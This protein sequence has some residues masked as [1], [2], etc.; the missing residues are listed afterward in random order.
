M[1][2]TA[3]WVA[4]ALAAAPVRA[5]GPGGAGH[6]GGVGDLLWPAVNLGLLAVLLVAK[7]RRP[8]SEFF[9]EESK[10]TRRLYGLAEKKDKESQ[11]RLEIYR[12]KMADFESEERRLAEKSRR[13]TAA[14]RKSLED[15]TARAVRAMRRGAAARIEG[16]RRAVARGLAGDLARAVAGEVGRRAA[17]DASLRGRI[18]ASLV[19]RAG[20]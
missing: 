7:A 18:A 19:S 15:G 9:A 14:F 5:A 13:E 3:S 12:K 6:A 8:L 20:A 1:G 16:E 10:R 2:R 17:A 11:I 4:W